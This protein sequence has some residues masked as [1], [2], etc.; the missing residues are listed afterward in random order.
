MALQLVDLPQD[1]LIV[2]GRPSKSFFGFLRA[3]YLVCNS[4]QQYGATA[5]RPT[6]VWIGRRYFDTTLGYPIYVKTVTPLVWV[7]GAGATV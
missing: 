4:E 1:T 7:N 2:G 6:D 3:L 5:Q